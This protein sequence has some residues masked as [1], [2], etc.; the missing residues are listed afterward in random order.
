MKAIY[1]LL[2]VEALVNCKLTLE[3]I[4]GVQYVR[5]DLMMMLEMLRVDN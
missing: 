3:A 5:L 1:G 4:A 2:G